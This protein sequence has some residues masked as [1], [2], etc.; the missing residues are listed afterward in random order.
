LQ[1]HFNTKHNWRQFHTNEQREIIANW[2]KSTGSPRYALPQAEVV[3][4]HDSNTSMSTSQSDLSLNDQELEAV[5]E[6][7]EETPG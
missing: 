1:S 7:H 3:S 2:S 5:E 4:I 6:A